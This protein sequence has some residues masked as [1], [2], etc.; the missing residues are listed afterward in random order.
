MKWALVLTMGLWLGMVTE[1][2][3]GFTKQA[4]SVPGSV[5][6]LT[7]GDLDGDGYTD[8]VVSY[9]RG[10]G[11]VAKRYLAVFF[12]GV[13][14]YPS[15][16]Q[17][18]YAVPKLTAV[19]DI[20]DAVGD[21][22]DELVFLANTGVYVQ[23]FKN[24][25]PLPLKRLLSAPT[26]VSGPEEEDLATWDFL[27]KPPGMKAPILVVP[28]RRG[29]RVFRREGDEWKTW[30]KVKVGL[31]S[32]YDAE[33]RT[34]RRSGRGGASGR[35]YSFRAT[36][37]VPNLQWVDQ[38]GDG[39]VDL[40][41][42]YQDRVEVFAQDAEGQLAQTPSHRRWF[43]VLSSAELESRDVRVSSRVQDLDGDGIADLVITKIG[44]GIT[45]LHTELRLFRGQKEGGFSRSPTQVF[46]DEGFAALADFVD[47][48]GDGVLEMVHPHSE[49]SIFGMS[50]ALLSKTLDIDVRIREPATGGLFFKPKPVQVLETS[51][52]LDFSVGAS[53][54]GAAPLFG[55]D[56]SGDGRPDVLLSDGAAA[57]VMY[58]GRGRPRARFDEDDSA[59]L[60]AEGTNTTLA[61]PIRIGAKAQDVILYYVARKSLAGRIFVFTAKPK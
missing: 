11:P 31:F 5:L 9:R 57:M 28:G 33:S 52:G 59:T 7:H 47:V 53:I 41:T 42:F 32:Y 29:L 54:R 44:G 46:S 30:A 14:G 48:D 12:R 22:K 43:R 34:Y 58:K 37:I 60:P 36:T 56:F 39:R 24:R 23:S 61:V 27:M 3:A 8:L 50:Q 20:G 45:T 4:L 51:Y 40:V 15:K 35:P 2:Q 49:V 55:H 10:S 13:D 21:A 25:K 38:T 19:F 6:W 17:V 16:P 18:A 26:L 1:A